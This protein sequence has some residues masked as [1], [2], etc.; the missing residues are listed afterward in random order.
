MSEHTPPSKATW[1][2]PPDPSPIAVI[3]DRYIGSYSGGTWI[4]ISEYD[5]EF[6]PGISRLSWLSSGD[7]G[8][9]D[10]DPEA[11]EFWGSV[12]PGLSWIAVGNSPDEAIANLHIRF[13]GALTPRE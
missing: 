3:E 2:P 6:S 10:D 11:R 8:P 9:L 7:D 1:P 4:A 12:A 13:N 5:L